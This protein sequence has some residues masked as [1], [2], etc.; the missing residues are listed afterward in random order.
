ML[1]PSLI[2]V[3]CSAH[4][5]NIG[6]HHGAERMNI[7]NEN[8]I[9]KIYQNFSIYTVRTKQLKEYCEFANCEYKRFLSHS[10]TRWLFLFPGI[11]RLLK[12]FSPLK[13][14]FLSQEHPPIVI[15]RFFE[16]EMSELYL[17]H[18]RTLMPV[19]HGRI[20]VVERENNSVAKVLENLELVHKVLVE[21]K[22]ENFMSLTVKRFLVEKR[23]EGNEDECNNFLSEVANLDERCLEYLYKWMK[24][25]EEFACFKWMTLNEKPSWKNIELCLEY[26]IG[27][28]IDVD[29]AKYFDQICNLK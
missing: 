8:N 29:D 22:N 28:G 24:P 27:K 26:L 12:M 10:K 15:K 1:N 9:N 25:M 14:Y 4:V 16:N 13:S 21:R 18:M 17:W 7:D 20:Q 11:L 19:F 5:L 2:G 3:G 23:K 6:I